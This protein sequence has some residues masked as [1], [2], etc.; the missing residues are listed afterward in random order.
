[1]AKWY[2]AAKK[3]DFA[4]WSQMFGIDPVV[5][6]V[7]RNRDIT[8]IDEVKHFLD[9]GR[10]DL[11]EPSLLYGMEQ[12]VQLIRAQI[13]EQKRFRIIGD[14][15]IDGV[16][17][18]YILKK[19][20]MLAGADVDTAIPHRQKD[21]Y[22]LSDSLI[23]A[24]AADG[25]E[26][27]ITCDN[28]IAA[29]EQIAYAKRLGMTVIVT[30]HHEV[31]YEELKQADGSI[32]KRELLP[33]ADVIIDPK[34]E[35]CAY[36]FPSICGA[37]VAYKL[38]QSLLGE[39]M[40]PEELL[41][42]AAFATIGD[43]MELRDENRIIVR[44]G[45]DMLQH[46][47]NP[48]L[49]ALIEVNG[50]AEK[51]LTPYHI[52]YILGPCLNASG[53]LDTAALSLELLE[54][55][56][57]RKAM[58]LAGEL[59]GLNDSR[60]DMTARGVEEACRLIESGPNGQD[61]VLVVFLPDCHESL[62]GIIAGRVRERYGRP[63]F[64]LTRGEDGIKGS[65]RSIEAFHMFEQM[66][67]CKELFTKYGGHK[68]AAG[69]S[70]REEDIERFRVCINA[71]CGLCEED[72]EETVRID[73]PMPLS[74][75]TKELIQQFSCLE[76]FGVGNPK[77]L[78]AQKNLKFLKGRIMGRNQNVAKYVTA[79]ESGAQ[80]EVIYF[81]NLEKLHQWMQEQFGADAVQDLYEGHR[82]KETDAII[83][84]IAY[85]PDLN[86]YQGRSSIQY[87]MQHYC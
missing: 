69:L 24:A 18:T 19:G 47:S 79:D 39:D 43:V 66:S 57:E 10:K 12:T 27:I 22:G 23:D 35:A 53:R 17:A 50:L 87:V 25:R 86:E 32:L 1:M 9:A 4:A 55:T 31:P 62:A 58:K 26:T 83:M 30:D 13:K 77:P 85:Y 84:S 71:E 59:K 51:T 42:F 76:P 52:G 46:S 5:A 37:V 2:V 8:S 67:R 49:R 78:F 41:G 34:Q 11:Y 75:V 70:M 64:I 81:G 40:L 82:R 60:K 20:L 72:F 38:V 7:I 63:T 16:C 61:K 28:G 80:Y 45:L 36:P 74:Y 33:Q 44:C 68:L 54:E 3:A 48:G 73:V 56:D 15:D 14:Y 6:R 65:G 29:A 21:G